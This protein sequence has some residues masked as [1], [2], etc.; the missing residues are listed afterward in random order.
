MKAW[1]HVLE[2]Q[3]ALQNAGLYDCHNLYHLF[4]PYISLCKT[5]H[6]QRTS[7]AARDSRELVHAGVV[8]HPH[9]SSH[10]K[11]SVLRALRFRAA[12]QYIGTRAGVCSPRDV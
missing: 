1:M 3:C 9:T 8:T 10:H 2:W 11:T 7:H 4:M 6:I 12:K 5:E